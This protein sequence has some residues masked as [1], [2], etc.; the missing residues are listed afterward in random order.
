MKAMIAALKAK[1]GM[2]GG[3]GLMHEEAEAEMAPSGKDAQ[4]IQGLIEQLSPAQ[5]EQL[6]AM[7]GGGSPDANSND[8]SMG[9]NKGN[10]S[11]QEQMKIAAAASEE[12]EQNALEEANAPTTEISEEQSDE[13]AKSMLDS[14]HMRGMATEKPRNLGERM[15]QSLASKLKMKGK[16]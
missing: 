14:R 13:I 7:L 16:I 3:S 10:P 6:K 1:R 9:I 15:K 4:A 12:N 2:G 8:V 11:K 5:I